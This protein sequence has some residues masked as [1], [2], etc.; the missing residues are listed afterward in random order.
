MLKVK[1]TPDFPKTKRFLKKMEKIPDLEEFR[2]Y[3]QMGVEAL[4]A[5][6][7][8]DTG[9]TALSWQ[10][11]IT[12]Q[13]GQIRVSFYNTNVNDGVNIAIILQ[14]GHGTGNGG[15]VKGRDYINPAVQPLFEQM[16][17][18]AWEEVKKA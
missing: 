10:Y 9:T 4:E 5:A 17:Q 3:G 11:E 7:P 2:K 18:N 14:Y 16:A 8:R 15:Y 1:S 13:N 6:T 12:N